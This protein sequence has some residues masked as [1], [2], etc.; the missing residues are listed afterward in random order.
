MSWRIYRSTDSGAPVLTGEAGALVGVLDACLIDGYGAKPAAGWVKQLTATNKRV[1]RPGVAARARQYFRVDDSAP[2][3]ARFARITGYVSMTD[4]DTGE[5]PFPYSGGTPEVPAFVYCHKSQTADATARPWVVAADQR[6]AILLIKAGVTNWTG[7]WAVTYMGEFYSYVSE[8]PY[9]TAL[10]GGWSE[11]APNDPFAGQYGVNQNSASFLDHQGY[12]VARNYNG[13]PDGVRMSLQFHTLC[14]P[15]GN[16]YAHQLGGFFGGANQA[17]GRAWYA[18][19][20]IGHARGMVCLRGRLRGCWVGLWTYAYYNDQDTFNGVGDHAGK[21]FEIFTISGRD[22]VD[23]SSAPR[24]GGNFVLETSN[25][26]E[27]S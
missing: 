3:S 24:V 22:A 4:I 1:Y 12:W 19:M 2:V 13:E 17:D 5:N 15:S 27:A 23:Q 26:V 18:R 6:T 11:S 16:Q 21:A 10:I 25:T 7:T 9:Q 14:A 8:D 20:S